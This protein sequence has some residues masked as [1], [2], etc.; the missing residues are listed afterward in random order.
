MHDAKAAIRFFKANA[1]T[2]SLDTSLFFIGGESAGAI[3][4]MNAS[5]LD[6]PSEV[7]Y[8][9]TNPQAK[10]QSLEGASGNNG[11]SAEVKATLCFCG[12]TKNTL[13]ELLFDTTAISLGDQPILF[14]HETNDALIHIAQAIEIAQ[15]VTNLN[16]PNLFYTFSGATHCPWIFPLQNSSNYLDTLINY[17][18]PFLY[19]CVQNS[20]EVIH[21]KTTATLKIF[22]N[23][24]KQSAIIQIKNQH[25]KQ[26]I[27][28]ILSQ[29]GSSIE[30]Q[31]VHIKDN[32]IHLD[33]Q[34]LSS[35][36]YWVEID[37][38][39]RKYQGELL[40]LP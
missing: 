9:P 23:P 18:V 20:T 34:L 7:N 10:D 24:A 21:Q 6:V 3:T 32:Q 13:N 22:P 39:E 26:G 36:L 33:L 29:N 40:I 35:G 25:S 11:Y 15:R 2:Y 27:L 1:T 4:A 19:A 16:I 30:Q 8:P 37:F 5:Y 31:I 14:V 38:P 28:K 12:G 17:T